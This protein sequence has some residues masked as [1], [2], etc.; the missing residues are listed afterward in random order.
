MTDGAAGSAYT[1]L[2]DRK[3]FVEALKAIAK[4]KR[5]GGGFVRFAYTDGELSIAMP[6]V[7]IRVNARGSWPTEVTMHGL[8]VKPMAKVPPEDDP[9][10][11]T[12][13]GRHVLIGTTVV[14]AV[15]AK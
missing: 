8:W 11:V 3:Q 12:C 15:R 9:V 6:N 10:S 5:R 4:F 7:T 14:P 13:D 1:L 2:V